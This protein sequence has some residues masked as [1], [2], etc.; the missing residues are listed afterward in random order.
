MI[1]HPHTKCNATS[2]ELQL[3]FFFPDRSMLLFISFTWLVHISC[4]FYVGS[5]GEKRMADGVILCIL[6]LL[7]SI[8]V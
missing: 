5:C 6:F 2:N 1:F 8:I 3:D 4:L 7:L